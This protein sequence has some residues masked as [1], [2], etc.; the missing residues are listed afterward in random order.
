MSRKCWDFRGS[1][2]DLERL[3]RAGAPPLVPRKP[4][5]EN[6]TTPELQV[7][8]DLPRAIPITAA[9]LEAIE[10]HMYTLLIEMCSPGP[11]VDHAEA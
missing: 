8:S 9:E 6:P 10:V 7:L 4:R 3:S 5:I 11:Y 1:K 2:R